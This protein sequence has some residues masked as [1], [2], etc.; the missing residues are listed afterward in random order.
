[1]DHDSPPPKNCARKRCWNSCGNETNRVF[2]RSRIVIIWFW[3]F[4]LGTRGDRL[5]MNEIR[6]LRNSLVIWTHTSKFHVCWL[7]SHCFIKGFEPRFRRFRWTCVFSISCFYRCYA[8]CNGTRFVCN[9]FEI[10][11]IERTKVRDVSGNIIQKIAC[12]LKWFVFSY[13]TNRKSIDRSECWYCKRM[14]WIVRCILT[15]V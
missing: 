11:R 4:S 1:M 9:M 10:L 15:W 7:T 14:F 6:R 2:A 8:T 12:V 13:P 5:S 3:K